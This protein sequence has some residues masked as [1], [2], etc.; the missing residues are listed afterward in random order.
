MFDFQTINLQAA[1]LEEIGDQFPLPTLRIAFRLMKSI[2]DVDI[3]QKID[4]IM[5]GLGEIRDQTSGITF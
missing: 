2:R 1:S 3:G 4:R 5:E